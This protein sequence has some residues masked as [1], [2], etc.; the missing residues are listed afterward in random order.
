VGL[1]ERPEAV[2][3]NQGKGWAFGGVGKTL[4][5]GEFRKGGDVT[6][7]GKGGGASL[8]KPKEDPQL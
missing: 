1:E 2:L 8:G 4:P 3:P 7:N 6:R 5:V